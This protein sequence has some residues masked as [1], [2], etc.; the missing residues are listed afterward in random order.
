MDPGNFSDIN[1]GLGGLNDSLLSEAA[2]QNYEMNDID[3]Y[4]GEQNHNGEMFYLLI[5][6]LNSYK[7]QIHQISRYKALDVWDRVK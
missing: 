3:D 1:D 2:E 4:T 5:Q 6:H 7:V